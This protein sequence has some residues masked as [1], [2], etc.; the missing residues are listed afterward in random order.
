M[1]KKEKL[2]KI[3]SLSST[4]IFTDP[5]FPGHGGLNTLKDGDKFESH[6]STKSTSTNTY[7]DDPSIDVYRSLA[8]AT[9]N[10]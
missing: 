6:Q 8:V 1:K 10:S 5:I 4:E 3:I 7:T 2:K 9:G